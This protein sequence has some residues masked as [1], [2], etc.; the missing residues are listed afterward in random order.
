MSIDEMLCRGAQRF[1]EK[2]AIYFENSEITYSQLDSEVDSLASGLLELGLQHQ[3]MVGL[4]LGNNPDFV[5]SYFAITRAGGVVVPINPLY[6]DEE[7]K[8]L[9]NQAG[10]VFL[11]TTLS[12][13]PLIQR[14]W[15]DLPTLQKVIVI[16]GETGERVVSYGELLAKITKP[17]EIAIKMDDTAA[18]LFTSGTTGKPKG[19]L[20]SHGNLAFDVQASTKRIQMTPDDKHLCV[21]PLF[22]SFALMATMLCPLYTGSSIVI[23]PQFHPD[24]VLQA[25]SSKKVTIFCGIPAMFASV[26]S[27]P[28]KDSYD[29]KSLHLCASGGAPAP[30][31]LLQAFEDKYNV[32]ILEGD[33]PTETSPVAYVNPVELR[34]IGSV[35]PP[36][37]GVRVKIVDEADRELLVGEIGEICIQGP[38]VMQGYLNQPEATAEAMKGG[39]FHTGDMGKV[40]EDGYIYIMDRKKD[41]IIVGG[42]N[43]YPREIE[44]CLS[45]HPGVAETA[46]IGMP[47][48]LRGE[49]PLALIVRKPGVK[50]TPEEFTLFCRKHL[51]NYKCPRQVI[52]IDSLP[53]TTTGKVDKKYL[54]KEY[55]TIR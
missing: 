36:L 28:E 30:V 38:N 53:R 42:L 41:M 4:L 33:G 34:K 20:L 6:K 29:L 44:D 45:K 26:L 8:Y 22:H 54:R 32:I 40:D 5:R 48:E 55:D 25:I 9:L 13:L 16:G 37:D 2:T 52:F 21:L 49:I 12:L 47:D 1:P 43:V 19:A 3:K 14:V 39:W 46:V 17:V 31:E 7:V 27:A 23:V 51:A 10:A 35:G 18:C 24:L 50:A 15:G 11:I